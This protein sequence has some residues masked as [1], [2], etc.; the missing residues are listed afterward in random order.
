MLKI[1]LI[2]AL[3]AIVMTLITIYL[4]PIL[5]V[6]Y[7]GWTDSLNAQE[8]QWFLYSQAALGALIALAALWH[9]KKKRTRTK[10]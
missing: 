3:V 9:W 7:T 1:R 8:R 10:T 4:I 2:A 5:I 6:A